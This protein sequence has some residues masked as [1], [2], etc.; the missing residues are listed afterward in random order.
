MNENIK[1]E[2]YNIPNFAENSRFGMMDNKYCKLEKESWK[3][4]HNTNCL[5]DP[6]IKL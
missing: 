6:R 3:K 5:K 4:N 1:K 2:K